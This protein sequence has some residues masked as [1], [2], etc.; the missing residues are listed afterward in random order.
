MK[1]APVKKKPA[2]KKKPAKK[3]I[4]PGSAPVKNPKYEHFCHEYVSNGR[5]GAQAWRK[6][7]GKITVSDYSQAYDTLRKPEIEKRIK[8]LEARILESTK[9]DRERILQMLTDMASADITEAFDENG[10]LKPLD[11]I[12]RELRMIIE[13]IE[14]TEINIGEGDESIGQI[15]KIKFSGR[16][17]SIEL[18]GKHVNVQAFKEQA[19]ITTGGKPFKNVWNVKPITILSDD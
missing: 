18:A 4:E 11:E 17:K 5:N 9:I 19:D 1:K 2:A 3:A 14:T 16:H 13:G 10:M 15:R 12:P 6:V 7:N 8:Y